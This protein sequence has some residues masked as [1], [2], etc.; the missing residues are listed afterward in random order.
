MI[1]HLK[2]HRQ[3][4]GAA[5][6]A[7]LWV[8][9][10]LIGLVA[11]VSLLL[12]QDLD[13]AAARRQIFRAR[14]VAE[15]ALNIALNPAMNAGDPLLKRQISED[16]AYEVQ[17]IGEGGKLD[18]NFLLQS[19]SGIPNPSS[20][21]A[22]VDGRGI[23]QNVFIQ[24][25]MKMDQANS[26]I[27]AMLDWIDENN[28]RTPGNGGAEA[29]E[30]GN[31]G[32][33][34]NRPFR[35]IEEMSLVRGM[36]VVEQAYPE[37]R[38]WFSIYAGTKFDLRSAKP[39]VVVGVTGCEM[40]RALALQ[41]RFMGR[42]GI[43]NTEDDD[44]NITVNDAMGSLSLLASSAFSVGF[45]DVTS[46]TKRY[47][48]RVQIGDLVRELSAVAQGSPPSPGAPTGGAQSS[49]LWLSEAN[50]IEEDTVSSNPRATR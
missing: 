38:S 11:G 1:I 47:V 9:A 10:M 41:A 16:E 22:T 14:M 24:W 34:F 29:K 18:P 39:E 40:R 13:A 46:Q 31:N 8:I 25:G 36:N 3:Q 32:M 37:W 45:F 49:I 6:L 30:Y 44:L 15:G 21:G 42:D 26:L 2:Q 43:L 4:S 33:P 50:P 48:V 27:N 17:I 7:V 28:N 19:A 20:P 5:L 35:S 23:L 12:V